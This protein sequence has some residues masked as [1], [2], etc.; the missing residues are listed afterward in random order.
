MYQIV[1]SYILNLHMLY[2][3]NILIK[4]GKYMGVGGAGKQAREKNYL[5]YLFLTDCQKELCLYLIISFLAF[6]QA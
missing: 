4:L 6:W 1:T 5:S 2:V 3:N